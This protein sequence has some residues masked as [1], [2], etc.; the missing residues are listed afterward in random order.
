MSSPATFIEHYLLRHG[1]AADPAR[2]PAWLAS[3]LWALAGALLLPLLIVGS[4]WLDMADGRILV[5]LVLASAGAANGWLLREWLVQRR[6]LSGLSEQAQLL[7]QFGDLWVHSQGSCLEDIAPDGRLLA[8]SPAGQRAMQLEDFEQLRHG[9]WFGL[10]AEP[11]RAQVRT[12]FA[13]ALGGERTRLSASCAT[14]GGIPTWWDILLVPVLLHG[15]VISVLCLSWDMTESRRTAR[16]LATLNEE[17]EALLE[18]LQEGFYRLDRSARFVEVNGRAEE[19]LCQPRSALLGMC[20]WDVLPDA[21]RSEL[22]PALQ[23][24][25]LLGIPRRFEMYLGSLDRWFRVSASPRAGGVSVLLSDITSDVQVLQ[26][27]QAAGARLRL[28]QEV[29][30]FADWEFD[31]ANRE[32]MLS[33]RALQIIDGPL[34]QSRLDQAT[35]LRNIHP[36]DRLRFV[37]AML[38]LNEGGRSLNVMVRIARSTILADGNDQWGYFQCSGVVI[39]PQARP[40][41]LLVGSIHDVSAQ[42]HREAQLVAA[43]AFTRSIIDA[44]PQAI[45]VLD[46]QA[47]IIASNPAWNNDAEQASADALLGLPIGS[48]EAP[49]DYLTFCRS[50]AARGVMPAQQMV[51]GLEALV[52]D[53]GGPF[54]FHY[55]AQV[56]EQRRFFHVSVLR[57]SRTERRMLVLH[58]DVT[59]TARLQQELFSQLQRFQEMV[60]FLPHVYWVFDTATQQLS[61]VSP[62]FTRLWGMPTD[63]LLR[64]PLAWLDLVHPDDR[65]LA[66]RHHEKALIDLLPAETEYRS[67]TASGDILWIRNRTFPFANA[68]GVVE[69]VVGIAED[70]SEARMYRDQLYTAAH[71]DALT[72]LPNSVMFHQRVAAQCVQAQENGSFLVLVMAIDRLHW[73]QQCLGQQVRDELIPQ[74]VERTV[75]TLAGNGFVASLSGD[76]LAI[77]LSREQERSQCL[78]LIESLLLAMAQPFHAGGQSI[79]LGAK[80]GLAHYCEDGN[81]PDTLL[82]NARAAVYSAQK[83]QDCGYSFFNKSL[84]EESLDSLKLEVELERAVRD[85]EFV[86]YYQPQIDLRRRRLCGA[87]ALLRWQHPQHGLVSPLRFIPLLEASGLIVTVGLWCVDQALS[88]LAAW[89]KN[90]LTDFTVAVN[91]SIKQMQP[92]LV[93]AIADALHRH[94][95]EPQ[96]LELELTE[97]M[98][99]EE[100]KLRDVVS[101]LRALGVRLAVDDFGTGYSTLGSLRTLAPDTL[102]IDRSFIQQVINVPSDQAIVQSVIEMAHALGIR[103]VAEGVEGADQ[104]MLMEKLSCDQVQGFLFSQPIDARAFADRF[105]SRQSKARWQKECFAG[106]QDRSGR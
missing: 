63:E 91:L 101:A 64:D 16:R 54:S 10:W 103:V 68:E 15:K 28:A 48:D 23:D 20:I 52:E 96:Y 105:I 44:L 42:Q 22:R 32:L 92:G 19:L 37:S 58:E 78:Q 97:S 84:L 106:L 43:E 27:S 24:V 90:G 51:E 17:R 31:L 30:G 59:E 104:L 29:G 49:V 80:F 4:P 67:C 47:R 5:L 72:G 2:Y 53:I 102:K 83:N 70:V 33:E 60:E 66:T 65:H 98:M 6:R 39:F 1:S 55:A 45:C 86:V 81:D 100:E 14:P 76:E 95:I 18:N 73:V 56:G 82:K 87:E 26:A 61:Y 13:R 62:A 69:R 7:A 94:A 77:L 93:P 79:R 8:M 99:H 89:R 71:F 34:H 25:M 11:E 74:V 3:A 12:A 9:D 35:L 38:D 36:D 40:H 50:R 88:Q 46:A 75:E 85:Q 57:L 41:G 21:A